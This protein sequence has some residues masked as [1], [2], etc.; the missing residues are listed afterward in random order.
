MTK[1]KINLNK[2]KKKKRHFVGATF[3][4]KKK[5]KIITNLGGCLASFCICGIFV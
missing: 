3:F 1:L 2:K 5:N 4:L